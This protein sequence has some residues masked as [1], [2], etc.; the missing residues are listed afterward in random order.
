MLLAEKD[1]CCQQGGSAKGET[2][3]TRMRYFGDQSMGT[4]QLEL[5]TDTGALSFACRQIGRPSQSDTRGHIAVAEAVNEMLAAQDRSK[6][7]YFTAA[8]DSIHETV[9][10]DE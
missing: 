7:I 4:E 3:A 2:I 5:A 8:Q 1:G 6:Q 9:F 10:G